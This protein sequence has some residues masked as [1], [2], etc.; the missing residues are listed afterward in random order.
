MFFLS[1]LVHLSS[2]VLKAQIDSGYKISKA[3]DFHPLFFRL[4]YYTDGLTVLRF[5]VCFVGFWSEKNENNRHWKP[6]VGQ[7]GQIIAGYGIERVILVNHLLARK[8]FSKYVRT[9]FVFLVP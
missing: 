6:K 9:C 7:L 8:Y 4:D 1:F 2:V 5:T 3:I